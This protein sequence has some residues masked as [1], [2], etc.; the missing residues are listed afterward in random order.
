[1]EPESGVTLSPCK[2]FSDASALLHQSAWTLAMS[3][4]RLPIAAAHQRVQDDRLE[5]R[6]AERT[7]RVGVHGQRRRQGHGGAACRAAL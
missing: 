1:M 4:G 6:E 7:G 5:E 3:D 2:P